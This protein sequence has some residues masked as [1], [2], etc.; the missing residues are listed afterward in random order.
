[1]QT[2]NASP[3]A[4]AYT[5][6]GLLGFVAGFRSQLPL[7]LLA[8]AASRGDFT[9]DAGRPP[10]F[11]RSRRTLAV[12]GALAAGG[13]VAETLPT[14]PSRLN[15]LPLVVRLVMGALVGAVVTREASASAA[16]G[17][18]VGAV[19]SGAGSV[20]GHRFRVFVP[21]LTGLPDIVGAL[22]E[23][24]AALGLGWFAARRPES[25]FNIE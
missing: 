9:R 6:A 7:F 8:V 10:S 20:V 13:L 3:I 2:R 17:S 5:R 11:L 16:V 1:M 22:V 23:D 24:V 18:A 19:A 15:P 21:H 12:L 25:L 14:M 4:D